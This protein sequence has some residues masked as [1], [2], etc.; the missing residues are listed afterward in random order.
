MKAYFNGFWNGFFDKTNAMHI[1]FFITLLT[2]VYSE[3]I[4]VSYN[5]D[6]SDILIESFFDSMST[7]STK[8][9]M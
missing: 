6:D 2:D 8:P 3:E 7:N 1:D 5:L 9:L 4:I